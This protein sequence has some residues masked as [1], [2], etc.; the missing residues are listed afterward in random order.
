MHSILLSHKDEVF[1]L[2]ALLCLNRGKVSVHWYSVSEAHTCWI[3]NKCLTKRQINL[4]LWLVW[5]TLVETVKAVK[6]S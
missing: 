3:K 1:Q 5:L 2:P 6:P 4:E